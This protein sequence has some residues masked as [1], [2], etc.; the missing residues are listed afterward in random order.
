MRAIPRLRMLSLSKNNFKEIPDFVGD[1]KNLKYLFISDNYQLKS[2]PDWLDIFIKEKMSRRYKLQGVICEEA[3]ALGALGLYNGCGIEKLKIGEPIQNDGGHGYSKYK[4][5]DSGNVIG[6]YIS[7]PEAF[8]IWFLPKQFSTLKKLEE[9]DLRFN[10]IR[11]IPEWIGKLSALRKLNLW[12]NEIRFVPTSIGNLEHLESLDLGDNMIKHI[13]NSIGNLKSLKKLSLYNNKI[14]FVPDSIGELTNLKSLSLGDNNLRR[15]PDSIGSLSS[16]KDLILS[17]N[18]LTTLPESLGKLKNL[19]G[20]SI[21]GNYIKD[22]PDLI[23]E[24]PN[25][26]LQM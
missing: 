20:L 8:Q 23:K 1:L 14:S 26:L 13:P 19:E 22:I 9:L 16:L 7:V 15:L 21:D 11:Y 24:L 17:N 2:I 10:K 25:V 12:R 3:T 4:I 18:K 6:L 5:S